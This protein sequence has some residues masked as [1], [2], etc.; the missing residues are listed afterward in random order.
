MKPEMNLLI[1]IVE[2]VRSLPFGECEALP[3]CRASFIRLHSLLNRYEET[4]K[5]KGEDNGHK[6]AK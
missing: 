6:T 1:E 2:E 5:L 3:W 4:I